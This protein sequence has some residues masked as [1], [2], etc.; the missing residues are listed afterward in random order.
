MPHFYPPYLILGVLCLFKV[1]QG[2][3][4][5]AIDC[6]GNWMSSNY[7]S[8]TSQKHYTSHFPGLYGPLSSTFSR[9][10]VFS[11]SLSFSVPKSPRSPGPKMS[12]SALCAFAISVDNGTMSQIS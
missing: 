8:S 11:R 4:L 9:Y 10:F 3:D 1:W 5:N 7:Q 2:Q 12:S 6:Q